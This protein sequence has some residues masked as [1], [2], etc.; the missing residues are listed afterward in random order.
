MMYMFSIMD[1]V[2][3]ERPFTLADLQRGRIKVRQLDDAVMA[4]DE[5]ED[6]WPVHTVDGWSW[7]AAE[8]ANVNEAFKLMLECQ[9]YD[10]FVEAHDL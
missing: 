3:L 9:A 2:K 7:E 1:E 8:V 5:T 10:A 6:W 4:A